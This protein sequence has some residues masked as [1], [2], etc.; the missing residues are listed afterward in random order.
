M[1]RWPLAAWAL[2]G[3]L[4]PTAALAQE[5]PGRTANQ[6]L[7]AAEGEKLD[8]MGIRI[9]AQLVNEFADNPEGGVKQGS[10]DA[11]QFQIGASVDLQ[12]AVGLHGGTFHF[13]VI[14]SFGDSLAK[15]DVGDFI[16]T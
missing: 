9:R 13:T 1:D 3:V 8:D 7:L 11:G 16:K 12:K 15:N 5:A 4:G 6:G 14:H 2:A 10:T